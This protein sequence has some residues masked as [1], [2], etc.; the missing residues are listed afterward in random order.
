MEPVYNHTLHGGL[1]FVKS[2]R[3]SVLTI[4]EM[5]PYHIDLEQFSLE[6]F[7]HVLETGELLP[8]RK[9]LQ[10]NISE[11]FEVLGS[12]GIRN[13][14]ELIEVGKLKTVIDRTYPLEQIVDAFIYVEGG[15]KSGN[16][17]IT[18]GD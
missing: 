17:A 2:D 6:R 1:P 12:M 10:E 16:V 15:H 7:R 11:R 18:V 5:H 9:V 14:K 8:G 13:L 4:P 3:T